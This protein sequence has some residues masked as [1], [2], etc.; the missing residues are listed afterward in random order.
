MT[1]AATGKLELRAIRSA[2]IPALVA[3]I[4]LSE[5]PGASGYLDTRDPRNKSKGKQAPV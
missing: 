4:Q 1:A 2:V 3:G 5:R